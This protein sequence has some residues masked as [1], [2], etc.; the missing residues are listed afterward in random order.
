MP[1]NPDAISAA[2]TDAATAGFRGRLIAR[3]QARAMIWRD[4]ILP[5]DAPAFSPQLSYDLH[6]L[7]LCA[8]G[9]RLAPPRDGR[10]CQAKRAWLSSRQRRHLRRS[11]PKAIARRSIATSISSWRRGLSSRA[12]I[13]TRLFAA[14]HRRR[15]REFLAYRARAR[16]ADAA[17]LGLALRA[18]VYR[19]PARAERSDARIA[20]RHSGSG[21]ISRR[22]ADD[23]ES[24]GH[25]FLFDGLDTRR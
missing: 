18:Q 10:R 20:G 3:G 7:R 5:P 22:P 8:L 2:I 23:E 19:L 6:S 21:S 25:D 14:R 4:G 24:E 17:G 11:W 1:T 13:G 16:A 9:P 15:R 12:P